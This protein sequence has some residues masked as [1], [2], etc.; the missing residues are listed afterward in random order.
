MNFELSAPLPPTTKGSPF[1]TC[2][3]SVKNEDVTL[4]FPEVGFMEQEFFS[5][6]L[7]LSLT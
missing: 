3:I 6:R 7:A 1:P 4:C 2:C 5:V